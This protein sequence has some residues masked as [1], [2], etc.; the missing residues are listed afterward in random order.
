M[1]DVYIND[2]KDVSSMD[3]NTQSLLDLLKEV[4]STD[5]KQFRDTL[6]IRLDYEKKN[7]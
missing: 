5:L 1:F 3:I 7:D 6:K 2:V 4:L